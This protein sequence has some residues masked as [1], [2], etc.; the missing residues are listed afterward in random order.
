[1]FKLCEKKDVKRYVYYD[2]T[3]KVRKIILKMKIAIVVKTME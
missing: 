3:D 1:M 2:C